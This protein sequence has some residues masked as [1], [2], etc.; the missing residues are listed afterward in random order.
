MKRF[1]KSGGRNT[2][3]D[4]IVHRE[5]QLEDEGWDSLAYLPAETAFVSGA[6]CCSH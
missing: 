5:H 6:V 2:W 3:S 4:G 1:C